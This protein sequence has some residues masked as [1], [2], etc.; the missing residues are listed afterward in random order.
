MI[1]SVLNALRHDYT[2][3]VVNG[4]R[5]H[6]AQ[7]PA[8]GR[9]NVVALL[10]DDFLNYG[11]VPTASARGAV[12]INNHV[13]TRSVT[14]QRHGVV[15]ESRADQLAGANFGDALSFH[16]HDFVIGEI[17]NQMQGMTL[18]FGDHRSALVLGI[19]IKHLALIGGFER[20]PFMC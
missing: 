6:R 13:V 12:L 14:D 16:I 15:V 20:C 17:V 18:T 3:A 2:P 7:Q 11:E 8:V 19:V 4:M 10:A 5:H 9:F 1:Q